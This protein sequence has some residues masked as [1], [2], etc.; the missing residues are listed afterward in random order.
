MRAASALHAAVPQ[1]IQDPEHHP[2]VSDRA[3]I[4]A[5]RVGEAAASPS[6]HGLAVGARAV[7]SVVATLAANGEDSRHA[8][9]SAL[10][11]LLHAA[12]GGVRNDATR[13]IDE[14]P[15][16]LFQQRQPTRSCP[17]LRVPA[18]CRA[19]RF[20]RGCPPG[21]HRARVPGR[22]PDP[23]STALPCLPASDVVWQRA[24]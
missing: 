9:R 18:V 16:V 17:G 4:D 11:E 5:A 10:S 6:C 21:A 20:S 24:P 8:R 19:E 3:W 14:P 23:G 1:L 12:A 22:D 13:V 15:R 2:E 7:V